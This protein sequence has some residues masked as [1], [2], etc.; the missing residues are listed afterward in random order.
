[1]MLNILEL[2]TRERNNKI[3]TCKEQKLQSCG[4]IESILEFGGE[5]E[6]ELLFEIIFELVVG[7]SI[8]GANDNELPKVVRICLL[9]FA[10]LIYIAFTAFFVWLL[11]S[12][13]NVF[14]KILA[15]GIVMLFVGVLISL[16]CKVLKARK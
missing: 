3:L 2:F 16:W 1:M 15:A 12:S 8:E 9:I 4:E 10:T 7:G 5:N 6:V 11:W 13:E 14:V